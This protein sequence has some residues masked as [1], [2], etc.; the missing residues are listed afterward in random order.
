MEAQDNSESKTKGKLEGKSRYWTNRLYITNVLLM[1][2]AVIL[3][4]LEYVAYRQDLVSELETNIVLKISFLT[5]QYEAVR[6]STQ[7]VGLPSFDF[8]QAVLYIAILFNAWQFI[9]ARRKRA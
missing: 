4:Y 7:I 1:I 8:F 2:A 3:A 9:K 5:F 6:G